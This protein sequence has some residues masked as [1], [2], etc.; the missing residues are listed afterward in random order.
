VE[1]IRPARAADLDDLCELWLEIAR[2]HQGLHPSFTLRGSSEFEVRKL[3]RALLHDHEA[4]AFVAE[5]EGAVG[6][7]S[8]VRIDRAPPILRE[9]ERAEITDLAVLRELRRRGLGRA[10]AKAALSWVRARGVERVEVRVAVANREGQ[11]FWRSLG[12]GDH[13]NVLNRDLS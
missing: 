13:V 5:A 6:G 7:M 8:C 1:G 3:L 4:A 12:F 9:A 2:H 10:L 11:A